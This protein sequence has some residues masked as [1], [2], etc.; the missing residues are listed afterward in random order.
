MTYD[1]DTLMRRYQQ[2]LDVGVKDGNEMRSTSSEGEGSGACAWCD[3]DSEAR[4]L[5]GV[6]DACQACCV[7]LVEI[8]KQ[9]SERAI[10]L[11]VR[12]G[13]LDDTWT[14]AQKLGTRGG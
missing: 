13:T 4:V 7:G 3:R 14:K 10:Q 2:M 11:E 5:A 1:P 8:V 12:S 9:Y 6:P